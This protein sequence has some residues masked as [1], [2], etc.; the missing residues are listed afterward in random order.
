M[1]ACYYRNKPQKV[2][3]AIVNV[4]FTSAAAFISIFCGQ[5]WL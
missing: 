1:I 5:L 2:N 3:F 4:N